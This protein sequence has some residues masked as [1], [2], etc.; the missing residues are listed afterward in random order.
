MGDQVDDERDQDRRR[1]RRATRDGRERAESRRS[2]PET[3]RPSVKSSAQPRAMLII[4]SV[5]MNG[6]SRPD[7][8]EQPVER[9][10]TPKPIAERDAE[11]NRAA[12]TRPLQRPTR[13]RR[14]ASATSEPTDRS[15]PPEMMTNVMPDRDDGV[16]GRLLRGR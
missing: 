5:A 4:P 10:R 9:D 6:G 8:I 11:R 7:V 16:D 12:G 14:P 15:M 13:A 3:G 2:K 1:D